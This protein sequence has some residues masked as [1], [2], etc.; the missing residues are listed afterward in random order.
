M[1]IGRISSAMTTPVNYSMLTTVNTVAP[2]IIPDRTPIPEGMKIRQRIS[3]EFDIKVLDSDAKF[4][5]TELFMIEEVLQDY[6][7]R[8]RKRHLVGVKNI[9]KNRGARERLLKTD[10]RATGAYENET[11]TIYLFD[12]LKPED[13]RE[14]LTHEIGHAFN[15]YNLEFDK[16]IE[17]IANSGYNMVEYRKYYKEG[18]A[19]YQIAAKRVELPKEKWKTASDRFSMNSLIKNSDVFGEIFL[20]TGQKTGNPW[21]EN[22]LE[23]FAWSYE[24]YVDKKEEFRAFAARASGSGDNSWLNG[25]DFLEKEVF[26]E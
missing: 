4:G 20:D 3:E 21:D 11:R 18:N 12:N 1:E 23:K 22:P 7:R 10:V 24:W 25:Y 19:F 26:K 16:F 17:Y 6:K 5:M 13:I 14:V 15:H 8:K 2:K 9:V